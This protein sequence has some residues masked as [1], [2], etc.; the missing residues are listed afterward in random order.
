MH[1]MQEIKSLTRN[2]EFLITVHSTIIAVNGQ[3]LRP[4]EN[5]TTNL[6]PLPEISSHG[7]QS[8]L[9]STCNCLAPYKNDLLHVADKATLNIYPYKQTVLLGHCHDGTLRR[10]HSFPEHSLN[11][12]QNITSDKLQLLVQLCLGKPLFSPL[13]YHFHWQSPWQHIRNKGS[14]PDLWTLPENTVII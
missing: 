6:N 10:L 3:Q 2:N 12:S 4:F 11:C 13:S 14:H 7:K 5:K 8:L 9:Y 1:R